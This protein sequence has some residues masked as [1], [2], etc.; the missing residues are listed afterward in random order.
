VNSTT[1]SSD[2]ASP[3]TKA[4]DS[5]GISTGTIAGIAIAAVVILAVIVLI[6]IYFIVLKSRRQRMAA[7]AAAREAEASAIATS[8]AID[9]DIPLKAELDVQ[10]PINEM[11]GHEPEPM[12]EADG[13]VLHEMAGERKDGFTEADGDTS[14][15]HEMLVNEEVATEMMGLSDPSELEA[16]ERRR[17]QLFDPPYMPTLK[18]KETK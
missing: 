11:A 5:H 12:P 8:K 1:N 6:T 7:E 13:T 9:P 14:Q 15:I 4:S 2:G 16:N 10:S 17:V 18:I 3:T